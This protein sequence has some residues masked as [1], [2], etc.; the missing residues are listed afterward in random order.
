MLGVF[1][2]WYKG[3]TIVFRRK[4]SAKRFWIDCVENKCTV[5]QYI[6]ELCR[7]LLAHPEVP[8]EKQHRVRLAFGTFLW[9]E[10]HISGNGLR[11]DIWKK[12][13]ERFNIERVGEFYASTEGNATLI[14]AVNK[15]N[16]V[17][18]VSKHY[19]TDILDLTDAS[20]NS[21]SLSSHNSEI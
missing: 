3:A 18:F 2:S 19:I 1:I 17:G 21:S 4:F 16:A 12:F 15:E 8:Q 10:S 11:P 5:I 20:V 7:Y 14:N 13:Q 9:N 6:G